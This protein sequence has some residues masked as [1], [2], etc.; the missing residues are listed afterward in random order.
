[1][2]KVQIVL[3]HIQ[4]LH[5]LLSIHFPKEFVERIRK[6]NSTVFLPLVIILSILITLSLDEVEILLGEN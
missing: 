1:M 6:N 4:I 3:I 5:R 2:I